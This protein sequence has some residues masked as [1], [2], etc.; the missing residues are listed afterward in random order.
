MSY[1]N[2]SFSSSDYTSSENNSFND[3]SE[4]NTSNAFA[5]YGKDYTYDAPPIEDKSDVQISWNTMNYGCTTI[6]DGLF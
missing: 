3:T 5:E 4:S 6:D 2:D 1:Q